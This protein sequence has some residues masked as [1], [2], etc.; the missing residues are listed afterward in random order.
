MQTASEL[1]WRTAD[2]RLVRAG[3]GAAET[4]A[5]APGNVISAK[6]E[7]LVPGAEPA[8]PEPTEKPTGKATAKPTGRSAAKP[9]DK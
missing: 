4:L 6:D 8:D 9:A 7:H 2:G 3:D 1:L 5:Y